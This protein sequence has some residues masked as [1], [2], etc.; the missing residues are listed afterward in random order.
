MDDLYKVRVPLFEGPLDLLLHLIRENKIDIYDI[1]IS[2]ITHQYL[3]YIELL[4]E[5]D[6]DIAGE[7]LVMA[8]TLI[9][10]KSRM[11][12]P[13][14]ET[15]DTEELE[16]PRLEL[17]QRL[18]AYREFR[19]ASLGLREREEQWSEVMYRAPEANPD[20]DESEDGSGELPLF[21]LNIFDL[22]M[23]L[24]KILD[25][26]PSEIA[27]ITKEALSIKD[28]MAHIIEALRGSEAVRFEDLFEGVASKPH[29]IITF[30][31]LLEA[32]KIG[33]ARVYQEAEFGQLWVIRPEDRPVE[34]PQSDA[35]AA[36]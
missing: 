10:I 11:L 4:K 29:L 24:R 26:V 21:N 9:H 19:D 2:I 25:R 32:I 18:L 30:I 12:L 1:P 33:L 5:L 23:A 3:E 31:A 8:A 13:I 15:A 17:V 27:S 6:L 16:D 35:V 20:L 36:A 22:L 14:E 7:F 28:S 34:T